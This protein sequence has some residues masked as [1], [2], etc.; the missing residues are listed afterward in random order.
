MKIYVTPSIPEGRYVLG[1]HAGDFMSSAA[2]TNKL[3][4]IA[5][6]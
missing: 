6:M 3:R 2:V 4:T 1:V 5:V